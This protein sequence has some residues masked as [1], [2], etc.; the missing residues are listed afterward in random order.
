MSACDFPKGRVTPQDTSPSRLTGDKQGTA[1]THLS[2]LL[3]PP[4]SGR[5]L[6]A[7]NT[8]CWGRRAVSP[9]SPRPASTDSIYLG[10]PRVQ[11]S[12]DPKRRKRSTTFPRSIWRSSVEWWSAQAEA[13][14]DVD[15]ARLVRPAPVTPRK[16]QRAECERSMGCR[17]RSPCMSLHR[18]QGPFPTRSNRLARARPGR[19]DRSRRGKDPPLTSGTRP[20]PARMRALE[21]F[22]EAEVEAAPQVHFRRQCGSFSFVDA[23]FRGSMGGSRAPAIDHVALHDRISSSRQAVSQ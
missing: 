2:R 17:R 8:T 1:G 20:T 11:H 21:R 7:A 16:A 4:H 10:R 14:S 9:Q 5:V 6:G 12:P 19:C 3:N 22:A 13:A 18:V 23:T 15:A